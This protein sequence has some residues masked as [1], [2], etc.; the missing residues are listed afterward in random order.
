MRQNRVSRKGAHAVRVF[1][2]DLALQLFNLVEDGLD[3]TAR[4][5]LLVQ[6][7]TAVVAAIVPGALPALHLGAI[8]GL[9]KYRT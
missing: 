4:E 8:G 7:P 1:P 3:L 5:A 2:N 6:N 9:T